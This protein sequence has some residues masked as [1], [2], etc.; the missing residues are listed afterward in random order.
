[1][2]KTIRAALVG[3]VLTG[4][5]IGL[6]GCNE[7][8]GEKSQTTIKSPGGTRTITETKSVKESGNKPP[9]PP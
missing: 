9:P 6:A 1:M 4:L 7:E 3:L 5:G 8:S 2:P